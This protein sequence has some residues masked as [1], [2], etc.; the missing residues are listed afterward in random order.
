MLTTLTRQFFISN[1]V[2]RKINVELVPFNR[3]D[4][5]YQLLLMY[6]HTLGVSL[7]NHLYYLHFVCAYIILSRHAKTI[8]QDLSSPV[9]L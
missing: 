7:S 3:K 6:E 4:P 2:F 5:S 8:R 1:L 9:G